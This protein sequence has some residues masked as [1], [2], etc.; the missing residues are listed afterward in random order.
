MLTEK[1]F[2]EFLE[3]N[4]LFPKCSTWITIKFIKNCVFF[5]LKTNIIIW[6]KFYKNKNEQNFV[7]TCSKNEMK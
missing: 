3:K 5:I 7:L 4:Q 1:K 2:T 6:G